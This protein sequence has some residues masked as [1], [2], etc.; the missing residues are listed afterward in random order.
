MTGQ[1]EQATGGGIMV[2]FSTVL[3]RLLLWGAS[4]ASKI[5]VNISPLCMQP[6]ASDQMVG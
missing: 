5:A 6:E 3:L 2:A 1:L 4:Y